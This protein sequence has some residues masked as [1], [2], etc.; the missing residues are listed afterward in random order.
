MVKRVM[1]FRK[2]HW[3]MFTFSS[4]VIADVDNDNR[5]DIIIHMF[6]RE[7]TVNGI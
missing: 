5:D 6:I 7:C 3:A 4:P 1:L 2:S